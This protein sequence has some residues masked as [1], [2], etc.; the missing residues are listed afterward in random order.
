LDSSD[1]LL[2]P[3]L[4]IALQVGLDLFGRLIEPI[5]R[6]GDDAPHLRA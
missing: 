3:L 1:R 5:D 4:E 2:A 6:V